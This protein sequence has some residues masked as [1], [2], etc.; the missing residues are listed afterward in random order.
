[1]QFGGKLVRFLT[2]KNCDFMKQN[3]PKDLLK[4][5]QMPDISRKE[6]EYVYTSLLPTYFKSINSENI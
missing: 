2:Q 5:L 1:M 4:T 3:S 6:K